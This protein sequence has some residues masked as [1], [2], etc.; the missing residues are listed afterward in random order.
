MTTMVR[1]VPN[2]GWDRRVRVFQYTDLVTVFAVITQRYV[3]VVDTLL[4]PAMACDVVGH[5]GSDLR[6]RELL[7]VNTHADW[8]HAWGNGCFDGPGASFPCPILGH[9]LCRTRMESAEERTLLAAKQKEEPDVYEGV[10][11]VPPTITISGGSEIHGED[12][13]VR[14]IETPGH[15]PDHLAL[16]LPE[17]SAL[18]AGD[19][20]EYPIPFVENAESFG[21]M[22]GS[23][24]RMMALRPR[25]VFSCHAAG[26]Y[27]EQVLG[28]NVAYFDEL[29]RRVR[30]SRL[31]GTPLDPCATPDEL[32]EKIDFG[33]DRASTLFGFQTTQDDFYKGAH[34][35]AIAACVGYTAP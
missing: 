15:R 18:L 11:L 7:V 23:L 22:R 31:R 29:E 25:Q 12:L 1:P 3:I 14:I 4:N 21:S 30:E 13:T 28:L 16:F 24:A 35:T 6:G 9:Q 5:L 2:A 8:D 20:A 33:W 32:A 10:T 34:L 27:G 17:I 19:A 26:R